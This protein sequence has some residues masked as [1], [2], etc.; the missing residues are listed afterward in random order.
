MRAIPT[1]SQWEMTED[2]EPSPIQ[3][4]WVKSVLVCCDMMRIEDLD[5][6]HSS[7]NGDRVSECQTHG[8]L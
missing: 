5:R 8:L 2:R 7:E 1:V 3:C 4:V 6:F